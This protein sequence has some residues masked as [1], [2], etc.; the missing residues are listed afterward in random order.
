MKTT[1]KA[2]RLLKQ[3]AQIQKM[4]RGKICRMTGR[5]HF[6]HQTWHEGRNIV[7]YVAH[8]YLDD[9]QEA[10]DG[11]AL[12]TQLTRQYADEMIRLTR[13]QRAKGSRTGSKKGKS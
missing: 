11:Y 7:R 10:V 2:E 3:I 1:K 12:F 13:I 4:E 6:N 9:L 8:E 5:S